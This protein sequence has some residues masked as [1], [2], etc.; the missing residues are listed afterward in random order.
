MVR[1]ITK[2]PDELP[3]SYYEDGDFH[4]DH[5]VVVHCTS[6]EEAREVAKAVSEEIGID[7]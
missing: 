5:Q 7:G 4:D 6:E 2:D 1:K 3:E